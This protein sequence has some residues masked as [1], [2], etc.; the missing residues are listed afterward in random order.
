M[1]QDHSG[2]AAL[3]VLNWELDSDGVGV[4]LQELPIVCRHT[5]ERCDTDT[6]QLDVFRS[7]RQLEGSYSTKVQVL[8]DGQRV[9]VRG[10]PSKFCRLDNLFG[11]QSIDEAVTVFNVVLEQLGLP[12]FSKATFYRPL[13]NKEDLAAFTTDGAIFTRIDLTMNHSVGSASGVRPFIRAISSQSIRGALGQL[14]SNGLTASWFAG[15]TRRYD[16][17][18]GKAAE[19]RA[20]WPKFQLT[21][22]DADY[23]NRLCA[24]VDSVGC[25]R[26]EHEL[27]YMKLKETGCRV[28][29]LFDE[30]KLNTLFFDAREMLSR[31][32]VNVMS[33]D[34]VA[35]RL[36][37]KGIVD[38]PRT[39]ARLQMLVHAWLNGQDM[40]SLLP[41]KSAF[42]DARSKLL[43][44]G[45]DIKSPCDVT[46]LMPRIQPIQLMAMPVPDFYRR[47]TLADVSLQSHMRRVA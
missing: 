9:V 20:H 39:A 31:V 32:E 34:D 37:S 23:L 46:R 14:S 29:G 1:Y 21:E 27:K 26:E 38:S 12:P 35:E 2:R 4:V 36:L 40:H 8:C 25:V 44:L 11:Y 7:P 16:K 3:P 13:Q 15:S 18:Y 42:Y 19:M 41:G 47:P 45:F 5:F 30:H 22:E 10:N 17:F 33:F 24:F 43:P 28:Y 6:G